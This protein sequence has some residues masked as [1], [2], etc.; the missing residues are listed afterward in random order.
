M[1]TTITTYSLPAGFTSANVL[2]KLEE[3]F[4]ALGYHGP[5]I[6]GLVTDLQ[7][8]TGGG[9]GAAMN[10]QIFYDVR[11]TS[12]SGSGTGASFDVYRTTEGTV[13]T[14]Q[15]NRP[16]QGYVTGD[17]VTLAA[18]DIGTSANGAT[19]LTITLNASTTSYGSPTTYF[20]QDLAA[21]SPWAVMR[22]EYDPAKEY[23]YTYRGFRMNG[24]LLNMYV[25]NSFQPL[26][27]TNSSDR[28]WGRGVAFR[29]C[30][31]LDT[32]DTVT[33]SNNTIT[34]GTSQIYDTS[35]LY[36]TKVF[37]SNAF[38]LDIVTYTSQLDPDFTLIQFRQPGVSTTNLTGN[39]FFT[40]NLNKYNTPLWDLDYV[41]QGGVTLYEPVSNSSTS[42]TGLQVNY[43]AAGYA[44]APERMKR[45]AEYGFSR[46]QSD[47]VAFED[48]Y[49]SNIFGV[50]S[51]VE[52]NQRIYE[53][54][55]LY[56]TGLG[57][58]PSSD[59]SAGADFHA[60]IKGIPL[61]NKVAP[62]PYYLPEEFVLI[63]F[64]QAGPQNIQPGDTVTKSASEVY[65][66]ITGGYVT[67]NSSTWG[68]LLACRTT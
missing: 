25:G 22:M 11:P 16:G 7:S 3:V 15:T 28:G 55:S 5:T 17:T 68:V 6:S 47:A 1:A 35:S 67:N 59:I 42:P 4:A 54:N 33:N 46:Y 27:T 66:V 20:T 44:F 30:P 52:Q 32:Y 14:V 40:F 45:M 50:S 39:T 21:T 60:A 8:Y 18:A 2:T 41:F 37:S 10:G 53:R 48:S 63:D 13:Y 65:T 19:N 38:P 62:S 49:Y 29:G 23:G 24:N 61:S 58:G 56:D 31:Y 64:T 9:T 26:T 34:S 12:T 36:S 43:F 51:S 57:S